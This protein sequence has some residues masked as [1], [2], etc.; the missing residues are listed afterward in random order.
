MAPPAASFERQNSGARNIDKSGVHSSDLSL[1]DLKRLPDVT[2]T[3]IYSFS[4]LSICWV[5]SGIAATFSSGSSCDCL[6]A[7]RSPGGTYIVI[8]TIIIMH[9]REAA[10]DD[11]PPHLRDGRGAMGTCAWGLH[12][13]GGSA[14]GFFFR[15][16]SYWIILFAGRRS[17]C[18]PPSPS[19]RGC[20]LNMATVPVYCIC[21]LPYDVTQFMIECDA[22][23]DWFHGR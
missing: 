2:F 10:Y 1:V 15:G 19:R 23:K 7:A 9:L 16:R 3:S 4:C 11:P 12:V 17:S 6:G 21:R 8:T 20:E 5:R 22:C 18:S 14:P 13:S